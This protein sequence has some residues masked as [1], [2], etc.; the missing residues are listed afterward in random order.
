MTLRMTEEQLQELQ[1]KRAD[2]PAPGS[3]QA[4]TPAAAGRQEPAAIRPARGQTALGPA[5][6]N[7]TETRYLLEK[8]LP[9]VHA[10]DVLT[11]EFEAVKRR[12][13]VNGERCWYTPDFEVMLKCG[14]IQYHEVKGGYVTEDGALKFQAAMRAYPMF[15]WLM[16]QYKGGEWL[17]IKDSRKLDR[18]DVSLPGR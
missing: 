1:R 4:P 9:A 6:M 7:K 18:V 2:K 14:E 11:Y 12:V 17:L 10:G 3:R 16:W 5:G 15:Q 13:S 8:L